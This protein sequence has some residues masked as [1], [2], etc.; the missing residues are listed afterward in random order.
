MKTWERNKTFKPSASPAIWCHGGE[1]VGDQ[2]NA[3]HVNPGGR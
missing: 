1:A 3:T 2:T